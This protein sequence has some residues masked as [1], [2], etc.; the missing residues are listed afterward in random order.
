MI[1]YSGTKGLGINYLIFFVFVGDR[2]I[3]RI[4][5]QTKNIYYG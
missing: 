1:N 3:L 5:Y 4:F 2:I